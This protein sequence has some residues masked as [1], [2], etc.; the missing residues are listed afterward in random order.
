MSKQ[1]S[2][3]KASAAPGTGKKTRSRPNPPPAVTLEP[4]GSGRPQSY[5]PEFAE[6]A[7][8]MAL[9][10]LTDVELAKFFNV[11][12]AT[13]YAWDA[14]H[15]EFFKSRANGKQSADGDVAAKLYHRACGYEHADTHVSIIAGKVVVTPVVKH[16]PPD[17]QAAMWWLKNRQQGRWKDKFEIEASGTVQLGLIA[18]P[19]KTT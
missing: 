11:D 4:R 16:Y 6:L 1:D 3:A 7:Y 8:R 2:T 5:K 12:D 13:I 18:M 14:K 9:L 10:G 17:T 19:P 15:P